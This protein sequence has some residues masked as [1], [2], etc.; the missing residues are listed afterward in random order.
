MNARKVAKTQRIL[1]FLVFL[2]LLRLCESFFAC[3]AA[4]DEPREVVNSLGVRFMRIPAGDF[5]MGSPVGEEQAEPDERPQHPVRISQAFYLGAYEV[6]QADF[7]LVMGE[8]PSWFSPTGGGR[9]LIANVDSKRLPVEMVSWDDAVSF[10][11]RLSERDEERRAGRTYRLPTEA[12]W[13]YACRAGSTTRFTFGDALDSGTATFSTRTTS[14]V[15]LYS[16][17]AWGLYDMHGNVWEWCSDW[18]AADAY[19]LK[20]P[21]TEGNGRVVRG[22]SYQFAPSQARSANRDFTR[23]TRRD[24]GNGLRVVME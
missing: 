19:S 16:P 3:S 15:G 10:C 24:W 1:F 8:N 6:T 22:G 23:P 11:R 4:A 2:A 18:Y 20:R 12:E 13:E 14:S 5:L 7:E 9:D 17:N 21:P